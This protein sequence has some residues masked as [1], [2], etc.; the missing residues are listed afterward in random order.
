MHY[1]GIQKMKDRLKRAVT[2]TRSYKKGSMTDTNKDMFK[3]YDA[4]NLKNDAVKNWNNLSKKSSSRKRQAGTPFSRISGFRG[5]G[6]IP[7]LSKKK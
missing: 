3:N 2:G 6:N 1:K 7:T 5:F 4:I